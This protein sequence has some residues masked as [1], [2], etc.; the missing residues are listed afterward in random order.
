MKEYLPA[1][2]LNIESKP[3]GNLRCQRV[4]PA[5]LRWLLFAALGLARPIAHAH[6]DLDIR[7]AAATA[8][9]VKATNN[10]ALYLAR[11]E[12]HRE[13]K[14]WLAA[15]ADYETATRLDPKL[16]QIDFLRG[17]MLADAGQLDQ[18]RETFGRHLARHP[19]DGFAYIERARVL[20]RLN[21]RT[22]AVADFTRGLE[23]VRE[24]QPEFFIERT[25]ALLADQHD[26]DALRGLD[27]GVEKLGPVVTLQTFGLELEL[28]QKK[29]DAALVRLE[30][31]IAQAA[32]QE[33]WLTQRGEIQLQANWPADARCS[34]EAALAAI[35]KLPMRLQTLPP[36]MNLTAR[37]KT[38]QAGIASSPAEPAP[39][40]SN[41]SKSSQ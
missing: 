8:E 22:N 41:K 40:A 25:Q 7:I 3:I 15:T 21:L 12:L 34:F 13:H 9:I 26:D 18:A 20:V 27:E 39:K 14:D 28:K 23:L 19:E 17:R 2:T 30:T 31:I 33:R 16:T 6:G 29:F 36:M 24:P 38:L 11:G 1:H 32:R 35:A 5:R 37:I 10:A 4:A